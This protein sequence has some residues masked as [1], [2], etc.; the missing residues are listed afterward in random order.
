MSKFWLS[1]KAVV[2][3]GLV[4]IISTLGLTGCRGG[5][6]SVE[7]GPVE[8]VEAFCKAICSGQWSEA[9]LLCD[10]LSM[11][12]YIET[13]KQT[14]ARLE[15]EEEGAMT[16]ARSILEST[17]LTVEDMSK[18]DDKRV[19]IYKIEADGLSKT[20]KATLKKEEGEWRVVSITEAN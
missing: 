16:V 17:V 12:E 4:V 20:K 1:L 5:Q 8:T 11:R 9:E 15:K 6:K 13:Q 3:I 7:M 18:N 10:S 2:R 14:W 19:V